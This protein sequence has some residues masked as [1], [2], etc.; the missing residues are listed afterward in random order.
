MPPHRQMCVRFDVVN[1][2]MQFKRGSKRNDDPKVPFPRYNPSPE[3]DPDVT[4]DD[5]EENQLEQYEPF[6]LQ[7]C[8]SNGIIPP[9]PHC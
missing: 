4:E 3:Q 2:L 6:F 7:Q 1:P 8:V 5:D 9:T